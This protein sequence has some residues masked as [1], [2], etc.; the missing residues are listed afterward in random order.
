M[1]TKENVLKLPIANIKEMERFDGSFVFSFDLDG[2]PLYLRVNKLS[3]GTLSPK[4]VEHR[5]RSRTCPF[6]NRELKYVCRDLTYMRVML[7][8]RLIQS[9]E[10]R[11]PWLYRTYDTG[12]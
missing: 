12:E 2:T 10:L 1:W 3:N 7:F 11:L 9:N 8:Q 4:D 5:D 6:C